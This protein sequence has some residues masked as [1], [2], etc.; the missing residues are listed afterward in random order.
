M[1]GDGEAEEGL[2]QRKDPG[3]G[4]CQGFPARDEQVLV[5]L[6]GAGQEGH[7]HGHED[8]EDEEGRHEHLVDALNAARDADD[9]DDEGYCQAGHVIGNVAEARG[10]AAEIGAHALLR[11]DLA[12]KR[13]HEVVERPAQDDGVSHG[14]G[15][16]A[17]R[18][19]EA[20]SLADGAAVLDAAQLHGLAEGAHGAG[21]HRAAE[22]HLTDDAGH[23][24]HDDKDQVRDE[25]GG[26]AEL[27]HPVGEE[28][29]VGHAHRAAH[30]GEDKARLRCEGVAPGAGLLPC[31]LVLVVLHMVLPTQAVRPRIRE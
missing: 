21:A 13:A 1:A 31:P 18:G 7:A 8:E 19:D 23:T 25:E 10:D 2:P 24:Q 28:P 4:I 17:Q 6:N 16:R 9:H 22:R 14:D 11:H 27:C 3:G 20:D 29:D 26:S 15:Q 30:A 12:R 5:A